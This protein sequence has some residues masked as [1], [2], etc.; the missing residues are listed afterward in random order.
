MWGSDNILGAVGVLQFDV[1][2]SRLKNEYSVYADYE[3][4][5]YAAARWVTC[6]DAKIMED[7]QKKNST[8]LAL[9]TEGNLVYLA[10]SEWRLSHTME[11]WPRIQF[12]KTIEKS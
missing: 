3:K 5:D 12:H 8:N 4:T 6:D 1:T 11:E 10:L 9:D 7:F 2:M